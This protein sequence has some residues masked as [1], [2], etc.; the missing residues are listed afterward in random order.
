V[1]VI[2]RFLAF[3]YDFIVGDDWTIAAGVVVALGLTALLARSEYT[4]LAWL[5]M[6]IATLALLVWSL[7]RGARAT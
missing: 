7:W 5:L 2:G 6:P 1:N 4:T 3:W